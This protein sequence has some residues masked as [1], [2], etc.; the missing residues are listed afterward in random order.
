MKIRCE[1]CDVIIVHDPRRIVGCLCDPDAPSWCY[2]EPSGEAK[3]LG[4]AKWV[5]IPDDNSDDFWR[6]MAEGFDRGWVGNSF[7][8]SHDVPENADLEM[9]EGEESDPCVYCLPILRQNLD[10]SD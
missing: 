4:Q 2:I 5:E 9:M 10:E 7:C 3:G 6:W 1:K 8:W